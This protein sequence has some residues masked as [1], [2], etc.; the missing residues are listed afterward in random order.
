VSDP[1]ITIDQL[2]AEAR[3]ALDR[4]EPGDAYEAGLLDA[5]IVDIRSE[6]QRARDGVI[7]GA[8]HI[9]RN[10]LEWRLDPRSEHRDPEI[11][12]PGTRV[13]LICH[14]GFQSSLTAVTLRRLGVDA[15]DVVGGFEAWQAAGLP[16]DRQPGG[17]A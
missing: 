11:A 8:R 7:P 10:V 12:Q 16:V 13:I 4:L 14:E 17:P 5:V 1:P 2:L 15:T 9:S 3:A 6:S